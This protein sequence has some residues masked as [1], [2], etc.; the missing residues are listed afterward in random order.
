MQRILYVAILL[1][2]SCKET[3]EPEDCAG[4]A[5]GDAVGTI[6]GV[7]IMGGELHLLAAILALVAKPKGGS[8]EP[9][10]AAV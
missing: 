5:G 4:V 10:P 6:I 2:F 8:P 3:T 7:V 9:E 1:I